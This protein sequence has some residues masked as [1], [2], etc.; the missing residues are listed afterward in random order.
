MQA[1]RFHNFRPRRH[2]SAD[3]TGELVSGITDH[4]AA[5]RCQSVVQIR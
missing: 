1:G 2:L 5:F 3:E 4:F